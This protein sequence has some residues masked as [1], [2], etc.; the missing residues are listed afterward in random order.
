M[1]IQSQNLDPSASWNTSDNP[2]LISALFVLQYAPCQAALCSPRGAVFQHSMKSFLGR[3]VK[4]YK[5][6]RNEIFE[7][8]K[9][10]MILLVERKRLREFSPN[11][12]HLT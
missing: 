8:E 7:D 1:G 6:L 3:Q 10:H 4:F 11:S 12:A 2:V 9:C 5:A